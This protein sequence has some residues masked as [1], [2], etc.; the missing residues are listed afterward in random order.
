M[1][2]KISKYGVAFNQIPMQFIGKI[3]NGLSVRSVGFGG[4]ITTR[5]AY[6][7]ET[8][9]VKKNVY[10]GARMRTISLISKLVGLKTL[11]HTFPWPTANIDISQSLLKL[12]E[13]QTLL[14][15]KLEEKYYNQK[16]MDLGLSTCYLNLEPGKGKTYIAMA[17]IQKYAK[18]TLYIV[19]NEMILTQTYKILKETF[20]NLQIGRY[21]GK[22]KEDGDVVIM[23]INSSVSNDTYNIGSQKIDWKTYF[24]QFGITIMD[25]VHEYCTSERSDM[26]HRTASLIQMGLS[27]TPDERLDKM[28]PISY[29]WIGTP[30]N[31]KEWFESSH[32]DI[33]KADG[34]K[35]PWDI[36]LIVVKYDGPSEYTRPI[37][38]SVGTV[39]APKMI[40]QFSC[41][42]YRS[43]MAADFI[44][45]WVIESP[46][47]KIFVYVDRTI[48]I[49]LIRTYLK[50]ELPEH[51]I[52]VIIGKEK[53]EDA[54]SGQV[55]LGTPQCIGTGLSWHEFNC[56]IYWHPRRNK[57]KQF[58]KRIFRESSDRKIKRKI[59]FIQDNATSLKSQLTG[60]T[61]S[62]KIMF[63][64]VKA[65][66]QKIDYSEI[67]VSQE[68]KNISANFANQLKDE[69]EELEGEDESDDDD[70]AV[71]DKE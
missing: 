45:N 24:G 51:K 53:N 26:F 35:E 55:V 62:W 31:V 43:Q 47:N 12:N 39:S 38:S 64:E 23:V 17:L 14:F 30:F 11:T 68:I 60:F 8:D 67:D 49:D 58:I 56:I 66:V 1:D 16:N 32:A 2:I 27:G 3:R 42:P 7:F 13:M 33:A 34:G 71:I 9:P 54:R 21:Y 22:A 44:Y 52:S 19:P 37:L 18:K 36:E 15:Q 61:K 10:Y 25:E 41:D 63:P 46:N 5:T 20:P 48:L 57:H 50:A 40:T 6:H 65:R 29:Y 59:I 69:E 70:S 28:D 4:K